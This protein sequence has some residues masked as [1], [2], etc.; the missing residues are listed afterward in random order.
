M[1]GKTERFIVSPQPV[2]ELVY[3][4]MSQIKRGAGS[5]NTFMDNSLVQEADILL[6]VRE[7]KEV[8]ST[9]EFAAEPH[10]HDVSQLYGII[11]ELT[12]EVILDGE[13]HEVSGPAGIFIPAGILHTIRPLKGSGYVVLS[14]RAGK[15]EASR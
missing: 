15:Y 2:E 3:H 4:N 9:L 6:H 11:G 14:M 12:I 1:A 10:K 13:R 7:V 5:H 8:P